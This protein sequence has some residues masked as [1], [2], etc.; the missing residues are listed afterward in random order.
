MK[1][2]GGREDLWFVAPQIPDDFPIKTL[3]YTT[4]DGLACPRSCCCWHG[5]RTATG[6]NNMVQPKLDLARRV[7]LVLAVFVGNRM[8]QSPVAASW[9]PLGDSGAAPLLPSA[10]T[11]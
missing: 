4:A 5:H 2:L 8:H 9:A 6:K 3:E 11:G 7:F 1:P 10:P